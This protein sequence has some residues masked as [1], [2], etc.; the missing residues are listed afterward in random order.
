MKKQIAITALLALGAMINSYSQELR[1]EIKNGVN[2]EETRLAYLEAFEK[3][4]DEEK[5]SFLKKLIQGQLE[6]QRLNSNEIR[7]DRGLTPS[8][9]IR[10]NNGSLLDRLEEEGILN[11]FESKT[12]T[13]CG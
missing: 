2:S 3:L 8:L 9:R 4:S 10:N 5:N 13:I 6:R 1:I 7:F 11:D 12:G